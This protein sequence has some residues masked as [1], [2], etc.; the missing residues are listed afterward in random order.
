MILLWK[1]VG[2][3]ILLY[4]FFH[5]MKKVF[6]FIVLYYERS[7]EFFVLKEVYKILFKTL[8]LL[9]IYKVYNLNENVFSF[10][11]ETL[12]SFFCLPSCV[13]N[14]FYIKSLRLFSCMML[15]YFLF[16][17]PL[18]PP[19]HLTGCPVKP[20][21]PVLLCLKRQRKSVWPFKEE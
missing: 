18:L 9:A 11:I 8:W 5:T 10:R 7:I 3:F 17:S 15:H 2:I 12:L 13:R 1:T 14:E 20:S 19:L 21:I 16:Q 4:F 6:N